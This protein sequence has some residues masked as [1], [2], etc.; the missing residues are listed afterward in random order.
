[1]AV[2]DDQIATIQ[3]ITTA[4]WVARGPL[5]DQHI[6]DVV[7]STKTGNEEPFVRI[8]DDRAFA[9]NYGYFTIIGARPGSEELYDALIEPD[10]IISVMDSDDT[11]LAALERHGFEEVEDNRDWHFVIDLDAL[12]ELPL[13]NGWSVREGISDLDKRI[14]VHRAAWAPSRFTRE[15][16]DAVRATPP[17]RPDLDVAVVSPDDEWA[18]YTIAWLDE[19]AR[20]GE[21]E[22]VGTAPAFRRRGLGRAACLAALHRLRDAGAT[23]CVVYALYNP[24]DDGPRR[25]YESLGGTVAGFHRRYRQ[26]I[27]A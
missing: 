25:L 24:D 10:A 21:L 9:L 4:Q 27:S 23:T 3:A 17:Y 15:K 20:M 2:T 19:E 12:S 14:G 16:Y 1:L 11:K 6:G 5:V 7:W 8:I 22:P 18:A 13:T 26:S